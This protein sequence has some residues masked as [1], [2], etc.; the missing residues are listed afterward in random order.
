[1]LI[2][3]VVVGVLQFFELPKIIDYILGAASVSDCLDYI[4]SYSISENSLD[5]YNSCCVRNN[6]FKP[7]YL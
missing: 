2:C 4:L 5:T 7:G 1:M 6:V 3:L